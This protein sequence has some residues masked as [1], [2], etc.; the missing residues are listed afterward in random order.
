MATYG[1]RSFCGP[2][3]RAILMFT[4]VTLLHDFHSNHHQK[5]KELRTITVTITGCTVAP[6]LC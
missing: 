1:T 2:D 4:V 3:A 5:M 6:A